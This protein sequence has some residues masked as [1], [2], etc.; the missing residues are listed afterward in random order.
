MSDNEDFK[1]EAWQ[2]FTITNPFFISA[3]YERFSLIPDEDK[4]VLLEPFAWANNIIS[5]IEELESISNYEHSWDCF[6]IDISHKNVN[7]EYEKSTIAVFLSWSFHKFIRNNGYAI[8][9]G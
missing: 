5:L 2:F 4:K 3:F 7:P 8:T 6:D 9:T 1:R